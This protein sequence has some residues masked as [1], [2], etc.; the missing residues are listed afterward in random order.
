MH[1]AFCSFNDDEYKAIEAKAKELGMRTSKLI[2]YAT[3]LFL[4]MPRT[5][6]PNVEDIRKKIEKY[7][8]KAKDETFICATPFGTEWTRMTISAKRTAA[9]QMK[10]LVDEGVIEKVH[11]VT[12]A[13]QATVYK[14]CGG[15]QNA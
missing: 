2:E 12:K 11:F 14:K 3:T 15:T 10:I 4:D 13:H 5:D 6:T 7:L 8:E 1:R 9:S